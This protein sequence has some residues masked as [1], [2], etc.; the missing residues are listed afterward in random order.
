MLAG[1]CG[2]SDD[3]GDR[4]RVVA[5]AYPLAFA[6]QR[7]GGDAVL[8]ENLT[9]LGAE[10][11]DVELGARDV[12][13]VRE[14][15]VVLYLGSD[16]QP[17]LGDAARGGDGE[18]VDLLDGAEDPHVWLDPLRYARLVQRVGSELDRPAAAAAFA[19]ELRAL[20]R[21]F[22]RGLARCRRREFVT[23]HAAFGHLARRYGLVQI[24][25]AG[26]SPEA[27]PSARALSDVVDR[28]RET[29]ATTVFLEPLLSRRVAETVAREAG[30]A[31]AV[32]DPLEGLSQEQLDAGENY[33][34]IM[35]ANL[36]ALRRALGCR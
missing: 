22:R 24:P 34:S 4:P 6:A 29:G 3:G 27:E 9:P 23:S 20:D 32:L 21:Q 14:A 15:E 7:V 31:T 17:A 25:I 30:A 33:F 19:A 26:L 16:F 36:R 12:R 11:H 28:V 10:P 5:G 13:R 2:A 18:A 1:A 35:R 8:V